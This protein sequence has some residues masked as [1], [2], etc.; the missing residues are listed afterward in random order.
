[1]GRHVYV[2]L[3]GFGWT[4]LPLAPYRFERVDCQDRR[5]VVSH[6]REDGTRRATLDFGGTEPVVRLDGGTADLGEVLDLVP[7]AGLDHWRIETTVFTARW[8][9]SF[10]LASQSPGP[11]GVL[12]IR[13]PRAGGGADLRPGAAPPA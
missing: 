12:P 11:G 13:P 10:A 8:P 5:V 2:R 1:M 7:G 9:A 6:N 4:L 3:T